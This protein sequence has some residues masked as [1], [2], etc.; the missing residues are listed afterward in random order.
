[1]SR[2]FGLRSR[3]GCAVGDIICVVGD[4]ARERLSLSVLECHFAFQVPV[5]YQEGIENRSIKPL[6]CGEGS[7]SWYLGIRLSFLESVVIC[8]ELGCHFWR[9]L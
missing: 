8:E 6:V 3:V 7:R 5:Y 9:G 4:I 2:L 1:M